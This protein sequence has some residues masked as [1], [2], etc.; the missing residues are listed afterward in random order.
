VEI[1]T[2]RDWLNKMVDP[3]RFYF[4]V[5]GNRGRQPEIYAAAMTRAAAPPHNTAKE[6]LWVKD[7]RIW[8]TW[9]PVCSSG[10][11]AFTLCRARHTVQCFGENDLPTDTLF[12]DLDEAFER[13]R[14]CH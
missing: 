8:G 10:Y 1:K 4:V 11:L 9:R 3:T 14:Q 2:Q 6:A 7:T 5:V 12:L 13:A